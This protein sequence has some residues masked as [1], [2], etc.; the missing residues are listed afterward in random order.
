MLPVE[1]FKKAGQCVHGHS[2][3]ASDT[4]VAA[5]AFRVRAHGCLS[6]FQKLQNFSGPVPEE[7]TVLCQSDFA[8]SSDKELFP[9]L[10]FQLHH[11]SG[12]SGLGHKEGIGSGCNAP[13]PGD[14]EKIVQKPRFN[15][16][17]ILLFC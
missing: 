2:L 17:S 10:L 12:Q 14:G 5:Q 8:F 7:D 4:D 11:L 6:I 9:K 16:N 1:I 15:H 3:T 13:F